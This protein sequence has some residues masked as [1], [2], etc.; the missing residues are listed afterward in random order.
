MRVT[1]KKQITTQQKIQEKPDIILTSQVEFIENYERIYPVGKKDP[2]LTGQRFKE[3][4]GVATV[5][6]STDEILN[7]TRR[8]F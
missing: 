8:T 3:L 4:R 6:I 2:N 5:K 7:L 1:N